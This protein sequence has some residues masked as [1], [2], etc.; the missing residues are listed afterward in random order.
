LSVVNHQRLE[1]GPSEN[2]V[3]E[4]AT[5]MVVF[6]CFSVFL[7]VLSI[8]DLRR[9]TI[10]LAALVAVTGL[11]FA[12]RRLPAS[13]RPLSLVVWLAVMSPF[14][15]LPA[16]ITYP[17]PYAWDEVAYSA[18]LPKVWA[19][20][21]RV[22]YVGDIGSYSAFPANYDVVTAAALKLF[23]SVRPMR[24]L[25]VIMFVATAAAS[26]IV[27]RLMSGGRASAT[28]LAG[29]LVLA[30]VVGLYSTYVKNDIAN[31]FFQFFTLLA[32]VLYLRRPHRY[33]MILAGLALGVAIG[34]KYNSLQF[35]A[36]VAIFV[37]P[38]VVA[39][40][41]PRWRAA[42]P[43]LAWLFG[44][45][46]LVA[47]PWYLRNLV[48]FGNPFY[49]FLRGLFPLHLAALGNLGANG[50][51]FGESNLT[52]FVTTV[53]NEFGLVTVTLAPIGIA[54]ALAASF[55]NPGQRLV[56]GF[57]AGIA[58][59]YSVIVFR[60][61]NVF[62]V[63]RYFIVLLGLYAAFVAA[64]IVAAADWIG[65]L[66]SLRRAAPMVTIVII[67]VLVCTTTTRQWTEYGWI[68]AAAGADRSTFVSHTVNYWNVAQW[69]NANL[70]PNN[71]IGIGIN[72]QPFFYIDR[73]YF[74]IL[75]GQEIFW[76]ASN[77]TDFLDKFH[78]LGL[79]HLAVQEWS[80]RKD[81]DEASY[82]IIH[83]FEN[84]VAELETSGQIVPVG[85]V[86]GLAGKKVV[87]FEITPA[88]P[89]EA[90]ASA[91]RS[92]AKP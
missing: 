52:E 37:V 90:E 47:A 83:N 14:V 87:F 53:A 71:R 84:A 39:A 70:R 86:D 91:A 4:L 32:I 9:S 3:R 15:A 36:C 6:A 18:V 11:V 77:A 88:S 25:G 34:I 41:S 50:F 2:G 81:Y 61:G 75:P 85:A 38:F 69:I 17:P 21:Q 49:P 72:V 48:V 30:P 8:F 28:M 29:A 73:S 56:V 80:E 7:S 55:V 89:A 64:A 54:A 35:A 59:L 12:L 1:I 42:W 45:A 26:G 16:M 13:P 78:Q 33:W 62:L 66:V 23:H 63:P 74:N 27:A 46:A 76:N 5:L 31:G 51:S 58:L 24:V 22:V 68:I 20:L 92:R 79:T 43:D 60:N 67:A 19:A 57:L 10:A 44:V 40:R 82:Q 65:R